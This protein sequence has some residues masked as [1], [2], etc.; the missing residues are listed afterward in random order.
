MA[1]ALAIRVCMCLNIG[2]TP[3]CIT[4]SALDAR[5]ARFLLR[6]GNSYNS[7]H[8]CAELD[9]ARLTRG[10]GFLELPADMRQLRGQGGAAHSVLAF[11]HELLLGQI[12]LAAVRRERDLGAQGA[13]RAVHVV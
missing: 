8:A 4:D 13:R 11:D 9:R 2:P 3:C 6:G 5:A 7:L 10:E 1:S 12:R